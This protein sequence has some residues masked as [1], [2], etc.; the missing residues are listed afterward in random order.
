[1]RR[2]P[3]ATLAAVALL[4]GCAEQ[5]AQTHPSSTRYSVD[6][7]GAAKTCTAPKPMVLDAAKPAQAAI[8]VA[9]NGGWCALTLNAQEDTPYDA[10]LVTHLPTHGTLLIHTVGNDT[11]VDYTPQPGYVGSDSYAVRMVPG[12]ATLSVSVTVTPRA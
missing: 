8:S 11:R 5:V 3:V 10:G 6:F 12:G 2:L 1:M 9:N 4:A 7:T